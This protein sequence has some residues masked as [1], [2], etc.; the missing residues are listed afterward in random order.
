RALPARPSAGG[1][2][3][4]TEV[5]PELAP[6]RTPHGRPAL[7]TDRNSSPRALPAFQ[8]CR[9][10]VARGRLG[11]DQRS[12][13]FAADLPARH[14]IARRRPLFAGPRRCIARLDPGQ[15]AMTR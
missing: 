5:A 7:H 12:L 13:A 4:S 9:R 2:A 10:T 8:R 14:P 3:Y 1:I 15:R 6:R 11:L